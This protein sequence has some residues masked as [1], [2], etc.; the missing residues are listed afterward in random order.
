MPNPVEA[1]RRRGAHW[2]FDAQGFCMLVERV[3]HNMSHAIP[4]PTFDHAVKDPVLSERCILP[5]HRIVIFEGLYL[6]STLPIWNTLK[7]DA[8]WWLNIN[9]SLAEERVMQR[10]IES[11]ICKDKATAT[12]RWRNNDALNAQTVLETLCGN[13]RP[14]HLL[15]A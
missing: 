13:T 12:E 2:T 14:I 5:I 7:F 6:A 10:H 1:Y 8:V 15:Q 4:F 9:I 3:R 11:G